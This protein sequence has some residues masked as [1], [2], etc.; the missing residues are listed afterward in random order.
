LVGSPIHIDGYEPEY[1]PAP[2]LD[3]TQSS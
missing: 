1:R 3:E 2:G